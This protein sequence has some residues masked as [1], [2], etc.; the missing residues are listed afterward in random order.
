MYFNSEAQSRILSRFHFALV[1]GGVLF[2][3]KAETLLTR[4][5]HGHPFHDP[6][7]AVAERVGVPIAIHPGYEP[8]FANTLEMTEQDLSYLYPDGPKARPPELAAEEAGAGC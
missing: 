4:M 3:G 5:P 6:L 2:L 1:E 7:W 8:E